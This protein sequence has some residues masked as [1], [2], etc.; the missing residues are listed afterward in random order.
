M[1]AFAAYAAAAADVLPVEPQMTVLAPRA[2]ALV[3]AIVMPRSLNEPEGFSPSY[4]SQ[5]SASTRSERRSA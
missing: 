2:F 1:P 4:F 5:T 3:I